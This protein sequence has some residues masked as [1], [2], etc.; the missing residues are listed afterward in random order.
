MSFIIIHRDCKI[1]KLTDTKQEKLTNSQ[2]KSVKSVYVLSQQENQIK[3]AK[4]KYNKNHIMPRN[5]KE[6]RSIQGKR[7]KSINIC[8]ERGSNT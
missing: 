5:K 2:F 3:A 8:G 4:S 1:Q 7:G 6:P